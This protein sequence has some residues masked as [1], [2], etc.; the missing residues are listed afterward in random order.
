[1]PTV[2]IE[3]TTKI[4]LDLKTAAE[5]FSGL[6]DEQQTDFFVEVARASTKWQC[7]GRW[8]SQ[9]WL[10]GRH[11]RDCK[12]STDDAREL[13]QELAAG[14]EPDRARAVA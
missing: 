7:Q 3:T 8:Q 6:S 4:T 2:E 10:V 12:C 11:L 9:Y 5:W 14:L 1:M 13:V